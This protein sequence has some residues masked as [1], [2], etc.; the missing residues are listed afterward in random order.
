MS[1]ADTTEATLE[2]DVKDDMPVLVDFWA[3]WCG[4]CKA[5]APHLEQLAAD[6][7]GRLKV[8]KLNVDEAPSGW[9]RFGVRAIPAL[10]FYADGKEYNRLTGPSTMRLRVMIEQWFRELRLETSVMANSATVTPEPDQA[11]AE[12]ASIIP[13]ARRSFG[14]DQSTKAA[15]LARLQDGS[16]DQQRYRPSALM[17]GSGN[18]FEAVVGVPAKLGGLLD[19]LHEMQDR[20]DP[21]AGGADAR[22]QTLELVEAM[23]VGVDLST[24]ADDVFYE[25]AF[26]SLWNMPQYFTDPD[27]HAVV[28]QIAA[29]HRSER[30]GEA[31]ATAEWEAVQRRAVLLVGQGVDETVSRTIESLAAPLAGWTARILAVTIDY[32]TRNYSRYPDWSDV[33]EK[34]IRAMM[35]ADSPRVRSELGAVPEAA[36]EAR[37]AWFRKAQE[38]R[39]TLDRQHRTEQPELYARYDGWRVFAEYTRRQVCADVARLL[40]A[41]LNA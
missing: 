3:P 25:L 20:G 1:I 15:C 37:E 32:A 38:L 33:E 16:Q 13:P 39:A 7:S 2:S 14:A 9:A 18:E 21:L 5:L 8:L 22:K 26:I 40:R 4:P 27:S 30:A 19:I 29:L 11:N 10:V 17:A 35:E 23:P 31:V 41:G 6:Y 24:L 34:Q 28:T 12:K 36:G